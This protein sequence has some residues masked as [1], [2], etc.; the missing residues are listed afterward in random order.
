MRRRTGA[1][2]VR[3]RFSTDCGGGSITLF[4]GQPHARRD[5]NSARQAVEAAG[6]IDVPVNNAG[7]GVLG[8]LEGISMET[9]REG[10]R[11]T[12]SVRWR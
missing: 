7:I 10:S 5:P 1:G 3:P 11:R 9:A 6:P 2:S 8:A 12:R 4:D